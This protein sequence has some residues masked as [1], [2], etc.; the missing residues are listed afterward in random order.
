MTA[1]ESRSA[2]A[3]IVVQRHCGE[4][5]WFNRC[6]GIRLALRPQGAIRLND[7]SPRLQES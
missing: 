1:K 7:L 6:V 3:C 2:V 5:R 4:G